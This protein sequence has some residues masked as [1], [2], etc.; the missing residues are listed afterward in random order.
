M[1]HCHENHC[2]LL[3]P[4]FIVMRPL[5]WSALEMWEMRNTA[6]CLWLSREAAL[7]RISQL[8]LGVLVQPSWTTVN[9]PSSSSSSSSCSTK[10]KS[11][12][13]S[14][15]FPPTGLRFGGI[16][17]W[18]PSSEYERSCSWCS[19]LLMP[20]SQ[21]VWTTWG[22]PHQWGGKGPCYQNHVDSQ[23]FLSN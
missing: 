20:E 22:T 8:S 13:A 17:K 6:A 4:F 9:L 15:L 16:S 2:S 23:L 1:K 18:L 10:K 5:G 3:Y 14:E 19:R 7:I 12:R 11:T 21:F